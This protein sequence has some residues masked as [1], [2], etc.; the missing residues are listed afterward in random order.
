MTTGSEGVSFRLPQDFFSQ[1]RLKK[2]KK[3]T[4][5][6]IIILISLIYICLLKVNKH[7]SVCIYIRMAKKYLKCPQ[8]CSTDNFLWVFCPLDKIEKN[9]FCN[10][11]TF[12]Y[13]GQKAEF[14]FSFIMSQRKYFSINKKS[15]Q[16]KIFLQFSRLNEKKKRLWAEGVIGE[17]DTAKWHYARYTT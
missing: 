6:K 14:V 8:S 10:L 7:Q 3:K 9:K 12:N 2:K 16:I 13:A 4:V 15:H 17:N 5:I 1:H 11:V